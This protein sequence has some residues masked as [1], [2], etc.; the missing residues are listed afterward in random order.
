MAKNQA[1]AKQHP[2]VELLLF[3]NYAYS[4]FILSSKNNGTNSVIRKLAKNQANAKQQSEAE[5]LLFEN[6]SHSSSILSSQ[7]NGTSSVIRKR[8]SMRVKI[9][10]KIKS[11]SHRQDINR[12]NIVNIRSV[13]AW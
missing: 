11:R 13:S 8:R 2:E 1:N 3:E 12:P 6:Y 4:S 9:K 7:I 5:L 10:V